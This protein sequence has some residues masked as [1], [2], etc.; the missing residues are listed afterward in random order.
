MGLAPDQRFQKQKKLLGKHGA[1]PLAMVLWIG[2]GQIDGNSITSAR[3]PDFRPKRDK[4]L[5]VNVPLAQHC[6]LSVFRYRRRQPNANPE[7]GPV[8]GCSKARS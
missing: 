2:R 6:K 5:A 3:A 4:D 1:A 8:A 7:I